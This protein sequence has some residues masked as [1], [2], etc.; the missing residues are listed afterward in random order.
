VAER[1]FIV[2]IAVQIDDEQIR[3]FIIN[4][5]R[6]V[7]VVVVDIENGNPLRPAI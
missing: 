3:P 1:V 5:L 7:A 4:M 2:W 6:A